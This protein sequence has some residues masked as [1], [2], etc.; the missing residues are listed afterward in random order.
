MSRSTTTPPPTAMG[1]EDWADPRA[2]ARASRGALAEQAS[3]QPRPVDPTTDERVF[4]AA[5]REFMGAMGRYKQSSGRM[6]PTWSEVLE[7][8]QGLGYEKPS[9]APRAA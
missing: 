3:D 9:R 7:V 6:F 1:T 8:L 4:D 5:E 2:Q